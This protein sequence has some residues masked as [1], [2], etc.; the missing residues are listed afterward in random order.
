MMSKNVVY[1]LGVEKTVHHQE[2]KEKTDMTQNSA[3]GA[4]LLDSVTVN[5]ETIEKIE[6]TQNLGYGALQSD[7]EI[8]KNIEYDYV[9]P[10]LN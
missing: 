7:S 10:K 6:M 9:V 1:G 5:Q 8:G 4:F 2:I 3:Y